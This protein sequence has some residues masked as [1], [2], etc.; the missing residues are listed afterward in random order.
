MAIKL[1]HIRILFIEDLESDY[2]LAVH[3]LKKDG[4]DFSSQRVETAEEMLSALKEFKPNIIISDYSM[5]LFNGME[6]LS[7]SKE[8]APDTPFVMLTGSINEETAVECMKAGASD[9]VI[10]ERIKRLPFAVKET[11]NHASL[12]ISKRQAER[13][14]IKSE[15]RFR[16]LA[17]NAQDLIYRF[18]FT[19][20]KKFIYVSPSASKITGYTPKEHYND[21]EL[22]FKLV[23]PDDL[24]I[25]KPI[26]EGKS[27][28]SSNIIVRWIKKNGQLIWTEQRNTLIL[29]EKSK[30]IAIEGVIR[31]ITERKQAEAALK[32][33]QQ[34]AQ[35]TL[36]SIGAN[37]CVVNE[38][39]EIVSINKSWE[40]FAQQN[41]AV[42]NKVCLGANYFEACEMATEP[43]KQQAAEFLDGIKQV[44]QGKNSSFLM[45]YQCHSPVEKRW[46]I[47]RV[48]PFESHQNL[49][50]VAHEN[51]T[52]QKMAEFSVRESEERY[53]TFLNSTTDIAYLKDKN[54]RYILVNKSGQDFFRKPLDE[55]IGKTDYE[56]MNHEL[57]HR[58]SL[59]DKQSLEQNRLLITTETYYNR[60]YEF[61][62]FPITLKNKEIGIGCFIRDVTDI[63]QAQQK[64]HES[65]K[66]YRNLVE[67]ALVGV[68]T[69]N[70]KGEFLFVNTALC[71]ILEFD[72][73][74]EMFRM[75]ANSLYKVEKD[76]EEILTTLK[77]KDRLN[78]HEV[79][80]VTA[81]GNMKTILLSAYMDK[82][83]ISGMMLDITER[84]KAMQEI[85]TQNYEIEK[86]NEEYMVLN[87]EL[88]NAKRKAEKSDQLKTAFL[89]NLSHEIRTPMNGIVGFTQL[90]KEGTNS[91]ESKQQY[92]EMIEES[93]DRLMNLIG[94]LVDISKIETG[95]ISVN[96]KEFDVN[97][98]VEELYALHKKLAEDKDI[99]LNLIDT[100]NE[101]E[102]LI[103]TD[104][105]KLYQILSKLLSN[106]L[107]F[108]QKG[109]VSFG[110]ST[111]NNQI[112]FFVK[113]TG[114]GIKPEIQDEIFEL[115]RQGDT[116]ISRGYEG[117]GLGLSITKS[118]VETLGG[119]IWVESEPNKGATFRF[120]L[121]ISNKNTDT[122]TEKEALSLQ[123]FNMNLKA[124]VVEDDS[125]SRL[126]I[127]EIL[128]ECSIDA[129]MATNGNQA[130]EV[131]KNN[132]NSIDFVLMDLKM[133]ILNGYQA[134]ERI[135][136]LGF[137]KPII[138]QTAYASPDDKERVLS[139][140]FDAFLTKPLNA[141]TLVGTIKELLSN[142]Q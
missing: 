54:S 138:A 136:E 22:W 112:E 38:T 14:L 120:T 45:E 42:W 116:S 21:S 13:A 44:L 113:D 121:P 131:I 127:E 59:S 134:T 1:E 33:V 117:V 98:L 95:Q 18:E 32:E 3:I 47:A 79:V 10:K 49:V 110:Y 128:K 78:N 100:G 90:L 66:K 23:H 89:Q 73:P 70:V 29:G 106:A 133:P 81:K 122:P 132:S 103:T 93:G 94:D 8:H 35:A 25:V 97:A 83:T 7:I 129:V 69:T 20:S 9:Y 58:N 125:V 87:E 60:I 65:E 123:P 119:N 105:T 34:M 124:L 108:T 115:F 140:G 51:I 37:I 57:A 4:L 71:E 126:L 40:E 68:Y 16:K 92:L 107:K 26:I 36:N 19:P 84:K 130:I 96:L 77:V 109:E 104:K 17:E 48:T 72:N 61:R 63:H 74:E 82:N 28:D 64:I 6:A 52:Q 15:E 31:D 80:M 86:K 62:K 101:D 99:T 30:P 114:I 50:V 76:R 24:H 41:S 102:M 67:N 12:Q 27:T 56:L 39:G 88:L 141:N 139:S 55:I 46:F 75:N 91:I 53:S 85:V 43:D 137:T 5:P 11:L 2:E 142:N 111:I 118:F 135:R